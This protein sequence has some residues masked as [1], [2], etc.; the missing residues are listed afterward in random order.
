MNIHSSIILNQAMKEIIQCNDFTTKYG[1]R[2]TEQQAIALV[3][4]RNQVLKANGRVEFSGGIINKIIQAFYDSPY[5]T[6]DNYVDTIQELMEIFYYYKNETEDLVS[7][8]DL[9]LFMKDTFNNNCQGSLEL[10]SGRELDKMATNLRYGKD[11]L[12]GEEDDG[13]KE[14]DDYGEY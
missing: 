11:P 6:K 1:L 9:I 12:D 14:D 8:D 4:T 3:E 10:L 5:I 13:E 2:L 7:D